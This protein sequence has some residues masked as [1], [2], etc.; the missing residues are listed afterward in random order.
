MPLLL[1]CVS[2]PILGLGLVGTGVAV[3]WLFQT[4]NSKP[5]NSSGEPPRRTSHRRS[6]DQSAGS[7]SEDKKPDDKKPDPIPPALPPTLLV[8]L[9]EGVKMEF[10]LIDPKTKPDHGKFDSSLPDEN[11]AS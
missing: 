5:T 3:Y 4:V 7:K 10:V 9:G 11:A 1:A 2:G 8:D 6:E